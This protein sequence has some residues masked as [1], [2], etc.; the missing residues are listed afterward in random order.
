MV[1]GH[2]SLAI[3]FVVQSVVHMYY[4][5]ETQA[6]PL[7]N[8]RRE[9]TLPAPGEV[10]VRVGEQVEPTQVVARVNQP[11]DF[12]ILPVARL[13]G[14]PA[15]RIRRYKRINLGDEV[16]RGQVI[17]V[18]RGLITHSVKSPIDG[19]MTASGGGRILIEA[20]PTLF[21]L[22]AYISGTVS[23]VLENHGVVIETAG[24]VIQGVWGAGG[25][26]FGV[27]K[28][29]VN[30][31]DKPLRAKAVDPSCH[32]TILVGGASLN[33]TALKRAQEL[34][35]RGIVIGG[36]PSELVSQVEQLPFPVIVTEGIGTVPMSMPIFRLLATNDGREASISGRVQ[37]RW[38]VVRPEIVIP[39]PAETIPPTQTQPGTPLTV[40]ARVRVVRAPR[41]GA[42]GTVRALPAHARR[43]ETGAMVRGAEV[44]LGQGAPIFIPL[45]NLEVLR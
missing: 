14:V 2:F 11:S 40:G 19:V 1:V 6:T 23:N 3:Q 36:L 39:L 45:A 44:D 33:E 38:G 8:V 42:V 7:T 27:L 9:R 34:Q 4:P 30:S 24:A 32:G 29:M 12:R 43:V 13:L 35:V 16:R 25:E 28:C 5:F 26:S 41:M 21:E 15:S 10:L 22:R 17:A 18:R 31:P 37:P 20:R